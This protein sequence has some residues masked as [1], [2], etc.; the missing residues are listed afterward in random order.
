MVLERK[1]NL[2]DLSLDM[3]AMLLSLIIE[4]LFLKIVNHEFLFNDILKNP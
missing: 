2:T 1:K 3:F 4:N